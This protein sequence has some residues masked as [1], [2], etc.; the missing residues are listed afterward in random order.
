MTQRSRGRI[1]SLSATHPY[2]HSFSF[3][4]VQGVSRLCRFVA[5]PARVS[6][7]ACIDHEKILRADAMK[8]AYE[9]IGGV[10]S[11]RAQMHD[12]VKPISRQQRAKLSLP[13][14]AS[15][16]CTMDTVS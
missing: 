9:A 11:P 3:L 8:S 13:L 1:V 12:D 4:R 6:P 2:N 16:C 14:W 7:H 15:G 10:R 5:P